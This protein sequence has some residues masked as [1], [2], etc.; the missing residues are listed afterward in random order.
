MCLAST[1]RFAFQFFK[2]LQTPWG[3]Y[4][5]KYYLGRLISHWA[6]QNGKS[7]AG[8]PSHIQ[9]AAL[10]LPVLAM[11]FH[12]FPPTFITGQN[13]QVPTQ[14]ALHEFT[15]CSILTTKKSTYVTTHPVRK[16]T[17]S[18]LITAL[19]G[20]KVHPYT[21]D[22][23]LAGHGDYMGTD[24]GRHPPQYMHDDSGA[25]LDKASEILRAR[26]A[27][28]G[29]DADSSRILVVLPYV[30]PHEQSPWVYVAYS[31][32]FVYS[33]L[34]ITTDSLPD[35]VP[36]GFEELRQDILEECASPLDPKDEGQMGFYITRTESRPSPVPAELHERYEVR[37]GYLSLDDCLGRN[38][39]DT[40]L[41]G[42]PT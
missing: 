12:N 3:P 36:R 42:Y 33:Q 25:T 37:L 6:H 7:S 9:Q 4:S 20:F 41:T 21:L 38:F 26:A 31:Y 10:Q 39:L 29:G 8:A 5:K 27:A 35:K 28:L 15:F 13:T 22:L 14:T 16:S 2:Q 32:V 30:E 1:R 19:R 17:M 18:S 34:L 40:L 24:I 23:Y 11:A